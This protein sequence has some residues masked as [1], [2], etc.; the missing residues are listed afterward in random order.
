VCQLQELLVGWVLVAHFSNLSYRDQEDGGL[1]PALAN[2][3]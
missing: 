2:S 3:L 1:K